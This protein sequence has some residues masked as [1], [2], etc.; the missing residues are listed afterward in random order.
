MAVYSIGI[1]G[2]G[3]I[4][5][6]ILRAADAGSLPV[7]VA[8]VTSR[9]EKTAREFL[10]TLKNPPRYLDLRKVIAAS[11]LAVEAAG[12][13]CGRRARERVCG[14]GKIFGGHDAPGVPR[15][16]NFLGRKNF[17]GGDRRRRFL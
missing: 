12:A 15:S 4:G 10:S 6:A 8:A 11:N 17:L 9:D 7:R 16:Q 13:A 5:R 2:V 3:A 14:A 1:V